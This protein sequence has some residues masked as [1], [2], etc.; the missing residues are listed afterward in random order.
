MTRGIVYNIMQICFLLK[1]IIVTNSSKASG[2]SRTSFRVNI[3]TIIFFIDYA[4]LE[5]VVIV[6]ID[7][8]LLY[9][10]HFRYAYFN[11]DPIFAV[12]VHI[13]DVTLREQNT[14]AII[15]N[16]TTAIVFSFSPVVDTLCS[17]MNFGLNEGVPIST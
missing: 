5:N 11:M 1:L 14:K 15:S 8:P 13:F 10:W 6:S 4:S 17:T 9:W 3:I 2:D 12:D 16:T 7:T